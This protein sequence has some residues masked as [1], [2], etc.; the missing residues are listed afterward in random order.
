MNAM[1][2]PTYC[3]RGSSLGRHTADPVEVTGCTSP[4]PTHD[5][6]HL[7]NPAC[8]LIKQHRKRV[9]VDEDLQKPYLSALI[10]PRAPP[11]SRLLS[12]LTTCTAPSRISPV[13]AHHPR[14]L[15]PHSSQSRSPSYSASVK[16]P[17]GSTTADQ[18]KGSIHGQRDSIARCRRSPSP[19]NEKS[20]HAQL[21]RDYVHLSRLAD[22]CPENWRI[23]V[24]WRQNMTPL[25][26][27]VQTH[28]RLVR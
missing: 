28:R 25:H 24:P 22:H 17:L 26:E 1:A 18:R 16:N 13:E 2:Q 15:Q 8:D 4:N 14:Y 21:R 3:R 19:A 5:A 9:L 7:A 10:H 27:S 6:C 20:F 11:L 23:K 12:P